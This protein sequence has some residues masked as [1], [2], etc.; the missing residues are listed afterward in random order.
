MLAKLLQQQS[1]IYKTLGVILS[2]SSICYLHC[3]AHYGAHQDIA[4]VL[5][6]KYHDDTNKTQVLGNG[7]LEKSVYQLQGGKA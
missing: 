6:Q 1:N 7:Y 2:K 5:C 3:Y 4:A